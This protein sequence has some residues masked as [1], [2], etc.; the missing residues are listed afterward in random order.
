MDRFQYYM[1][2][3]FPYWPSTKIVLDVM[4]RRKTWPLGLAYFP[5]IYIYKTLKIFLSETTESI[6]V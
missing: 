2:E 6:S 1:A 3:M 4:I 5:Y